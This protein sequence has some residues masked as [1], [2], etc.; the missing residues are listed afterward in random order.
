MYMLSMCFHQP[1]IGDHHGMQI[2]GIVNIITLNSF[3][4]K[5]A[6]KHNLIKIY[7]GC[8]IHFLF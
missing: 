1:I 2:F 8:P 5:D 7:Q 6:S 4:H 3:F